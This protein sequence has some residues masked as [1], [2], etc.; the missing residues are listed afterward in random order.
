MHKQGTTNTVIP[1][2]EGRVAIF[3]V[4]VEF[5][6]DAEEWKSRKCPGWKTGHNPP[7]FEH[8]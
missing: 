2:W 7:S 3:G 6:W 1:V 4:K 8:V 5:A